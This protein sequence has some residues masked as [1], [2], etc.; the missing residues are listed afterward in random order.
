M[1]IQTAMAVGIAL[2]LTADTRAD[3]IVYVSQNATS[4]TYAQLVIGAANG[5]G[6]NGTS[7]NPFG[8]VQ[9]AYA[10][11]YST[12]G[13]HTIRL[14]ADGG[15]TYGGDD[16]GQN[17]NANG[18]GV[19]RFVNGTIFPNSS[20]TWT[21]VKLVSDS[22]RVTM[23]MSYPTG[24]FATDG[25]TAPAEGASGGQYPAAYE[26]EVPSPNG[27]PALNRGTVIRGLWNAGVSMA[28]PG[29]IVEDLDIVLGGG[30]VLVGT[31]AANVGTKQQ[32]T[33]NNVN[34]TLERE[35][36]AAPVTG[37]PIWGKSAL[38]TSHMPQADLNN[39][40]LSF[41]NSNIFLRNNDDTAWGSAGGTDGDFFVGQT[42][43]GAKLPNNFVTGNDSSTLNY[44]NGSEYVEWADAPPGSIWQSNRN[45]NSLRTYQLGATGVNNF[46]NLASF[47][48]PVP[49][50]D[51]SWLG[52]TGGTGTWAATGGTNWGGGPWNAAE[53]AE[54]AGTPGTVTVDV[55]GVAANNGLE[56]AVGG[57]TL[58]G[59][60]VTLGGANAAANA[61]TTLD[62]TTTINAPLAGSTGLTKTGVGVLVLGRANTF[63]G[64]ATVS[65]GTLSVGADENLG[66]ASG[67]ITLGGGTLE[68]TS[69][70]TLG[71][72]RTITAVA[73]TTSTL[74]V[75]SGTVSYGGAFTGSGNLDKAGAGRLVVSNASSGYTGL[76]TVSAGTLE[77]TGANAFANASLRQT[78]GE[79]L[80]APVGGG[81]VTI[82]DLDGSGGTLTVAENV[83][84][85]VGGATNS[86]YG[87]QITGQG[88]LRKEGA[89]DLRLN[90]T[91]DFSGALQIAVGRLIL[92]FD[93]TLSATPLIEIGSGAIFDLTER[94]SLVLGNGQQLGGEG[95]VLG[96]L[97]FGSGALLAFNP[98]ATLLVGS[99]LISFA[100]GFG[101]ANIVGL[102]SSTEFG[103]YTLL[104]ETAE[105]FISFSNLANVGLDNAFDIGGGKLAYFQQGSLQ[106]V[107]VKPVPEPS[108]VLL[109]GLGLAIAGWCAHRRHRRIL[110]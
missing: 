8:S 51:F 96:N 56:F 75:T 101:I 2:V 67:G 39:S 91:N 10:Y 3:S 87:G 59:D 107:V 110:Q 66:D 50:A 21:T 30:H 16:I 34:V 98:N 31:T 43:A 80:L 22:T 12:A 35:M 24:Q 33:F 25:I 13:N 99:G 69:S 102:N 94:Y 60:P 1:K 54:F 53:T 70:F 104:D 4:P 74:A 46:L 55:G 6:Q 44:W 108:T 41:T 49:P 83:T 68:M 5:L 62:G 72:G 7:S 63:S 97:E 26:K 109:G 32:F 28:L 84:A 103:T 82:P 29:M 58:S 45:P 27:S 106:L 78:G 86:T 47:V 20:P 105:G 23:R 90:G 64:G 38:F 65:A 95:T 37:N 77:V 15:G 52:G 85:V 40:Y 76:F 48:A 36:Y 14:L 9:A 11:L 19:I 92:G 18:N 89:G 88:G 100:S 79:L 61:I 42:W 81:D 93:G 71:S 73:S 17:E 57:Y